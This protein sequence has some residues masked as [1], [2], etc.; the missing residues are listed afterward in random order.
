[1]ASIYADKAQQAG[2]LEQIMLARKVKGHLDDAIALDP[3]NWQARAGLAQFYMLAPAIV[4]GSK[5]KAQAIA[6]QQVKDDP[7]HGWMTQA[8]IALLDKDNAKAEAAYLNA[9]KA[10]PQSYTAMVALGNFYLQD[11]V[12]NYELAE[13]YARAAMKADPSRISG[14]SLLAAQMVYTGKVGGDL[15]AFLAQ[16]EKAVPDDWAPYYTAGRTLII[17]GKDFDRA[18]RYLRKYL[19]QEAEGNAPKHAYT[20]WR[21]GQMYAKSGKRDQAI[22]EF[23]AC[24]KAEPN[25][26]LAKKDLKALK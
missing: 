5:Q 12:K 22:A 24:L 2:F 6:D 17:V 7:A 14:Y 23:E 19:S 8:L 16:A 21:L 1:M 13:K 25:F 18:E 4:G 15:D 9:L 26:E 10:D 3:R 20:H 11:T